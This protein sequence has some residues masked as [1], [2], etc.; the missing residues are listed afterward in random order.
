MTPDIAEVERVPAGV[1]ITFEDGGSA[2]YSTFLL[3]QLLPN[4]QTVAPEGEPESGE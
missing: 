2:I 1:L 4:A 3:Y